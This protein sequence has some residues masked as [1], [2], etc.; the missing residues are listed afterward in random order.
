[1]QWNIRGRRAVLIAVATLAAPAWAQDKDTAKKAPAEPQTVTA[2]V[3]GHVVDQAG[4]PV[5][6]IELSRLWYN[7]RES[8]LIPY[9]PVKTAADGT[10]L[11]T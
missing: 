1:M 2:K 8:K 5:A 7:G 11:S 3:H 9:E 4:R 10:S 6:D